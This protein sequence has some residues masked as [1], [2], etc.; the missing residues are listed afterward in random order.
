MALRAFYV[1]AT[2]FL[3]AAVYIIPH[4]ASFIHGNHVEFGDFANNALRIR[5]AKQFHEIYGNWSRYGFY[6]PGPAFWYLYAAGE[7]VFFDWLHIVSSPPFAHILT[8]TIF[9][10]LCASTA[11]YYLSR[12]LGFVVAPWAL[13]ILIVHWHFML[14]APTSIWPPHVLFGP[15]L[16]LIV[17]AAGTASGDD[18][19]LPVLV[20]AG[21]MLVHGHVAQPL[22]V[23]PIGGI[24]IAMWAIEKHRNKSWLETSLALGLSAAIAL[25]FLLPILIDALKGSNSNIAHILKHLHASSG[26]RHNLRQG[27]GYFLSF[28]RYEL[29]QDSVQ[30]APGFSLHRY[31]FEHPFSWVVL[32]VCTGCMIVILWLPQRQPFAKLFVIFTCAACALSIAWGAFQDGPM[33]AFNGNFICAIVYLIYLAPALLLAYALRNVPL[34]VKTTAAFCGII[35][36]LVAVPYATKNLYTIEL[37]SDHLDAF[38][39]KITAET[40]VVQVSIDPAVKFSGYAVVL[41]LDRMGVPFRVDDT[42][43]Y[44]ER[45][46]AP[47]TGLKKVSIE[48]SGKACPSG[49]RI[50]DVYSDP[51]VARRFL[52]GPAFICIK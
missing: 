48:I 15:V 44:G 47:E 14:G 6:H 50:P 29:T 17:F 42:S 33:A 43:L 8:G 20:F 30:G 28:F 35:V 7:C 16:L 13:A 3:L 31:V 51:E 2:A 36:M 19:A 52:L 11:I 4:S 49:Y 12:R 21:G 39:R 26:D 27:V 32:L 41:E 24:A 45:A 23:G 22:L 40:S 10:S 18:K 37:N 1:F 5:D 34:G 9:Q 38:L 25:L 46:A